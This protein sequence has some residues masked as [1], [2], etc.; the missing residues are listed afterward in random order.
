LHTRAYLAAAILSCVVASS[1]NAQ[2]QQAPS[3]ELQQLNAIVVSPAFRGYLDQAVVAVEQAP[4]KAKCAQPKVTGVR[5][6]VPVATLVM[7][8]GAMTS[9]MWVT[10]VNID[11][12]GTPGVRRILS[13]VEGGPNA[14][15]P[16]G[17]LPGDFRGDLRLET[18][19]TKAMLSGVLAFSKCADPAS[20]AVAD[21]KSLGEPTPQGWSETWTTEACGKTVTAV[22][23]YKRSP[24]GGTD[25]NARDFKLQ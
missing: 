3:P 1:A 15:T 20:V 14:L 22:V 17:L 23:D 19:I 6:F 12:C 5:G 24:G 25:Y 18:D 9:G 4:L 2:T 10:V 21:I 16:S 7:N 8:G 11:R 13:R